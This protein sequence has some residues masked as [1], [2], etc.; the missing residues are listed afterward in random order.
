[1]AA[2]TVTDLLSQDNI[3]RAAKHLLA[4]GGYGFEE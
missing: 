3:D 2:I 1:M 4:G